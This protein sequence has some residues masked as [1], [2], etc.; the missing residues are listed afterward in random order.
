LLIGVLAAIIAA[1]ARAQT[2]RPATSPSDALDSG[3]QEMLDAINTGKAPPPATAPA[4]SQPDE[5]ERPAGP[6]P[7]RRLIVNFDS[8]LITAGALGVAGS[9]LGLFVL[10]RREALVALAIPQVVAVGAAIGMRLN[11]PTLPPALGLAVVALVYFALS[12]RW[13][14]SNWVIPS[15]YIAGLCLSFL[16]IA[17]HGQDVEDLQH[18]FVGVDVAVS[19]EKAAVSVPVLLAVAAGCALLWRRWLLLAQAPAA[20]E[21]AGLKPSRWDTLFLALLTTVILLGTYSLT[22]V[23]VLAMLFLPAATVLPWARRLPAAMVAAA[24]FA[25][26]FV[27]I[28]FYLSNK[29]N[30]PLSQSIGGT[31]FAALA[32]S[33]LASK[34]R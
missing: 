10:L 15:A 14:A 33:H 1:T 13:A 32:L 5:E 3:T 12:K 26:A 18:M 21:L 17:N 34:F 4:E 23:M 24:L 9:I 8:M 2:T 31:G 22:V 20:A 11:W 28:G 19:W 30:W 25:L 7:W 16:V 6:I 29:M 27:A